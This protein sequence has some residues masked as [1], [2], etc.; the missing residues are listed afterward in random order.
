M[1][2]IFLSARRAMLIL[3]IDRP[4]GERMQIRGEVAVACGFVGGVAV[5]LLFDGCFDSYVND[6]R[7]PLQGRRVKRDD[8]RKSAAARSGMPG[9]TKVVVTKSGK[10][11]HNVAGCKGLS[12]A[13][14]TKE[15]P[16]KQAIGRGKTPCPMCHPPG[17]R[18]P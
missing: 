12:G 8:A 2:R 5:G 18:Q 3:S 1:R 7:R 16:L 15:I 9:E 10:R 11:Y 14:V 17:P 4:W 13:A 6:F